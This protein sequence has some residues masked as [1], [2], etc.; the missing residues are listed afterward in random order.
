[1]SNISIPY[2]FLN[3]KELSNCGTDTLVIDTTNSILCGQKYFTLRIIEISNGVT[4]F[5]YNGDSYGVSSLSTDDVIILLDSAFVCPNNYCNSQITSF[6]WTLTPLTGDEWISQTIVNEVVSVQPDLIYSIT[7]ITVNGTP[8]GILPHVIWTDSVDGNASTHVA[9][10]IDSI[11]EYL[12]TLSIPQYLGAV[13]KANNG[14]ADNLDGTGLLKLY[15]V[16]GTTVTITINEPTTPINGTFTS[17]T[18][19]TY[20][21]TLLL[22][23]TSTMSDGDVLSQ[24]NYQI[25]DGLTIIG[26]KTTPD[27][28]LVPYNI[29]CDCGLDINNNWILNEIA[30][31]QN[32]CV[33]N[34]VCTGW[35][36]TEDIEDAIQNRNTKTGTSVN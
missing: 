32:S 24:T 21:L 12:A 10:Y 30:V 34:N 16:A 23:D 31:T 1:M 4:T 6:D 18:L 29:F 7:A 15:F 14:V 27:A 8:Y 20:M 35:I 26:N 28:L 3:G 2:Q 36:S 33:N 5:E 17:G 22:E 25:S 13:N 11:I 9:D 19:T